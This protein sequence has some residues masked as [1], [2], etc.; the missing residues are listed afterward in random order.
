MLINKN[1]HS[2]KRTRKITKDEN[3]HVD[4][5]K[6]FE[7][8]KKTPSNRNFTPPKDLKVLTQHRT[9]PKDLNVLTKTLHAPSEDL[10]ALA[11]YLFF[12]RR[13]W[14]RESRKT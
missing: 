8:R 10:K 1:Y 4:C 7:A 2:P 9:P 5:R 14:S 12:P 11:Q 13:K 6:R 3:Q